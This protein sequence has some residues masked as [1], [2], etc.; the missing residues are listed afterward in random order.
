MT[1][2]GLIGVGRMGHGIAANLVKAGWPLGFLEHPG[3]QPTEDLVAAGA[4]SVA[5]VSDLVRQSDVII[6]V[7]TGAPQVEEVLAGPG[8]V[9]E[10]LRPDTLVID[11]STSL[12]DITR[13]MAKR[14][15]AA[16]GA[17]LDAPMTRT[18]KEAAEGRLNLIVGGD[19]K[20]L[21]A[22]RPMLES[23]A[24]NIVHAGETGSGHAL[25][26]LHNFVSLGF[27]AVL[28]EA[29][30]A[31]RESGVGPDVF[32]EVLA[33]GGGRG[34]VLDRLAPYITDGDSSGFSF[35]IANAA[36]DMGYYTAMV[37]ALGL[38]GH[39]A[40][41]LAGVYQSGEKA[42]QGARLVPELI[43]IL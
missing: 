26:L 27:S 35:T 9:L 7:V 30:I 12:P 29:A 19:K 37:R 16:G 40:E 15:E 21:D 18:P 24:E 33:Q 8:G 34:A 31:A 41:A 14:V 28:V 43:S 1:K 17:L 2:V 39:A 20:L 25:K 4:A 36:K 6:L 32:R 10:S 23:F 42:G 13:D 3:N 38:D 5:S 22:H 11:C